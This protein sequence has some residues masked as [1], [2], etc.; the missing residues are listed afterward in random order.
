MSANDRGREEQVRDVMIGRL[1]RVPAQRAGLVVLVAAVALG[2]GIAAGMGSGSCQAS[3]RRC[4]AASHVLWSRALPG[5]WIA[6]DGVEGTVPGQGQAY[7]AAG[8]GTAVIGFGLTVAAFDVTTGFPRWS[9]TLTGQ[10]AGSVIESVNVFRGI[11]AVGIGLS[12]GVGAGLGGPGG[13][14][15][16]GGPARR[17]V[18]LDSVTGKVLR[19]YPAARSGGAVWASQRRTVIV[20]A[21][22]VTAYSN[23]S[24]DAVWRDP[25]GPAEQA[26]RVA[27][28][29]LY[30]AVTARGVLGT[31]PVTAVR[32]IDLLTGSERLIRP[33]GGSFAGTLAGVVDGVLVFSASSGLR[34][35][36][37]LT[38][39]P[40]GQRPG[41][42]AESIDPVEHVLY[43]DIGGALTGIDPVTGRNEPGP[44]AAMPPGVYGVR[45]GVALGLDPGAGG[46]A[47]GYSIA[48]R[49]IVWTAKSLPYPHYFADV[50]G[51]AGVDPGTATVLLVT[52][53]AAGRHV[54]GTVVGGDG[55]LCL[56]P[57]LVALG[58]WG[59]ASS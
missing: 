26:W 15:G 18:V 37:L 51:P 27:G 11:V 20:G 10:P 2:G 34:T 53:A 21:T 41:A 19:S 57:R 7:A 3:Q 13:P 48:R 50:S 16:S 43:A 12:G 35:Y 23:A 40:A 9:Q 47:W 42:V 45:G 28:R 29:K 44:V 4:A 52:C 22:S 39:S 46:V 58:P 6:H 56:K 24:G 5:T 32:Q 1:A 14:G 33:P 59:S 8:S 55:Q 31:S 36:S 30:V 17:E 25:T 54:S 38:G 49:R